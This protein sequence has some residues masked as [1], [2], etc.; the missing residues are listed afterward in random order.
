MN[1]DRMMR[2]LKALPV[3]SGHRK[4]LA[5][6][7]DVDKVTMKPLEEEDMKSHLH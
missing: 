2:R 3:K 5:R 1:R 7:L 6:R 4:V